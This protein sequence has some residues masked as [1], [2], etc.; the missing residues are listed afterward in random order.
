M[1]LEQKRIN[2]IDTIKFLLIVRVYST[3]YRASFSEGQYQYGPFIRLITANGFITGKFCVLMFAVILGYFAT[4][5]G[6]KIKDGYIVNR[7]LYFVSCMSFINAI[8]YL[9]SKVGIV[10]QRLYFRDFV[11][12]TIFIKGGAMLPH[13]AYYLFLLARLFV[14]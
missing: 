7:Y 10:E 13:G 1:R 6:N 14:I 9:L 5:A 8:Y 3:H 12:N 11:I 2:W 4:M